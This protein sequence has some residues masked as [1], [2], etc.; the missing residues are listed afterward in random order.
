[1]SKLSKL[2]QVTEEEKDAILKHYSLTEELF[3]ENVRILK[4]WMKQSEHLPQDEN[5]N[6]LKL[7]LLNCKM[8]LEKA[9]QCLEGY[10]RIRTRYYK[11]FFDKLVP[12]AKEYQES[13]RLVITVIM[14]KLTPDLCRITIFKATD[15]EGEANDAYM[16]ELP[17]FMMAEMRITQ[18]MCLSNIII[19]DFQAYS[20]KNL[21]KFTPTVNQKLV[22]ML[23][24]VNL[25]IK[26][27]HFINTNNVLEH[28]MRLIK[29]FLPSKLLNKIHIHK[30]SESLS[31]HIPL[32]YLP[33][34]YG[35]SEKAIE[36]LY[37][38]WCQQ[39]DDSQDLF[40]KLLLVKSTAKIE[41][42]PYQRD[43]FGCGVDGSFKKLVLD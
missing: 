32:E 11:E 20:W 35:G 10:Y 2:L 25:R 43:M 42:D 8:S 36:D 19:V 26:A 38:E 28:V 30:T 16:Y 9:K 41:L 12:T 27:I 7:V 17:L 18:E 34:N 33:S 1:M 15:P 13:K 5:D 23:N 39:I 40:E 3:D 31:G 37:D 21:M 4:E 29:A 24:A 14:P 22:D 6:K